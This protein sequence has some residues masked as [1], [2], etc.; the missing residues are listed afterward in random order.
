MDK[1]GIPEAQAR[2]AVTTVLDFIKKKLPAPIAGQI[3]AVLSSGGI[4][5]AVQGL[6]GLFKT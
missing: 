1:T 2:A 5:A 4:G 3:D 6:G